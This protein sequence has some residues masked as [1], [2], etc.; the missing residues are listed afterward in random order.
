M[1]A[2]LTALAVLAWGCAALLL[3]KGAD[4]GMVISLATSGVFLLATAEALGLLT[5][6]AESLE[7]IGAHSSKPAPS[8]A[9]TGDTEEAIKAM[10]TALAETKKGTG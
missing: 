7:K 3:F 5:R 2:T 10:R 4:F 8:E 6:I 1:K 9:L